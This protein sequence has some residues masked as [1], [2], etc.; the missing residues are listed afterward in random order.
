MARVGKVQAAI[1]DF[2]RLGGGRHVYVGA[3][4]SVLGTGLAGYYAEELERPIKA[5]VKRGLLVERKNAF[6][7]L[8][9]FDTTAEEPRHG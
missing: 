9:E 5:L 1:L 8:P 4:A 7:T 2:V 3:G 6:Y